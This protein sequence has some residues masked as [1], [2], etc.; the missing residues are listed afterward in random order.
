MSSKRALSSASSALFLAILLALVP[1]LVP[2]R[3]AHAANVPLFASYYKRSVTA[4]QT[5]KIWVH[6]IAN[7]AV[8]LA[9]DYGNGQTVAQQGMTNA[10]GIYQFAWTAAYTGKRVVLAHYL[11]SVTSGGTSGSARGD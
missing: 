8:S 1:S 10:N 7:A 5:Q 3:P 2:G 4:G 11:V 9:V 6:T